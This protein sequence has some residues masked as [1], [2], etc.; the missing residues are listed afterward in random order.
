MKKD[1]KNQPCYDKEGHPIGWLSRSIAT[2]GL[3]YAIN[4]NGDFYYL[5]EERGTGCPDN[6]GKLCVPCGYLE[7]DVTLKENMSNEIYQETG[8]KVHP[9]NISFMN[10][11]DSIKE[12]HQNVSIRFS[13]YCT[14]DHIYENLMDNT[15]NIDTESRGGEKD[16]VSK[17]LFLKFD[18]I[19]SMESDNFAFNHKELIIEH[20]NKYGRSYCS[21]TATHS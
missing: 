14:Y 10:I 11:N 6:I 7:Y 18:D 19:L 13:V 5:L 16:E 1:L 2:V 3:V 15:I 9:V 20:Y 8:L 12:N 21:A 17:I 4:K